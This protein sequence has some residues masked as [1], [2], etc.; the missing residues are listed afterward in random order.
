MMLPNFF[1]CAFCNSIM[2]YFYCKINNNCKHIYLY[3]KKCARKDNKR[4]PDSLLNFFFLEI[5]K[6]S[7]L[8]LAST[9]SFSIEKLFALKKK[10]LNFKFKLSFY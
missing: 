2:I 4:F 3:L 5:S 10:N 1:V 8:V 7:V 9:A 6:Y